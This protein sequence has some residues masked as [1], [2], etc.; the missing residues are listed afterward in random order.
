MQPGRPPRHSLS[1]LLTVG[2]LAAPYLSQVGSPSPAHHPPSSRAVHVY[3]LNHH[4]AT[5]AGTA[6]GGAGARAAAGEQAAATHRA[7]AAH[8]LHSAHRAPA[9]R[10]VRTAHATTDPG[11]AIADF[12]FTPGATTI[13]VGDTITWTN[14]GPSSHTATA[15]DGSFDTGVLSRGASASHTFTQP[16][17]F[18]Y[19]CRIHPFMHATVVVLP[20][21]PAAAQ[22][23]AGPPA[24]PPAGPPAQA[25][26]SSAPAHTPAASVPTAT[27]PAPAAASVPGRPTLP[28]TGLNLAPLVAAGI[29]LCGF[30]AV[31]RRRGS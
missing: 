8:A 17:T 1:V 25:G 9:V 11:V 15:R 13:H 22:P 28:Q 20:A 7:D 6:T 10:S 27:A 26:S 30:G 14:H 4:S 12:S 24:Q 31:L 2:T 16:G 19:V 21:A 23:P 3:L 29:M 5:G 18:S